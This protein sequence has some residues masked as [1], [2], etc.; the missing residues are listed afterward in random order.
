MKTIIITRK[1]LQF[2]L[3][4]VLPGGSVLPSYNSVEYRVLISIKLFSLLSKIYFI[5]NSFD[6]KDTKV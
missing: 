3:E 2:L 1:Y 4:A 6:F 5:R